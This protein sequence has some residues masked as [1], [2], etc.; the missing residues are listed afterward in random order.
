MKDTAIVP[1]YGRLTVDL[2]ADQPGLSLFHYLP[3]TAA[4]G[5]RIQ[6]ALPLCLECALLAE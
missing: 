2:T 3:H 4:H 5:L 6:S 1:V